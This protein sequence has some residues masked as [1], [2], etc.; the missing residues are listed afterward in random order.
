MY[1]NIIEDKLMTVLI[2]RSS[3]N[4]N[5]DLMF[6]WNNGMKL[7]VRIVTFFE[8][9]NC[10]EMD[11]PQYEEYYACE[12][13]VENVISH[14]EKEMD[15]IPNTSI[16]YGNSIEISYRNTPEFIYSENV[17]IFNRSRLISPVQSGV[18]FRELMNQYSF[19]DGVV[20]KYYYDSVKSRML[21]EIELCSIPGDDDLDPSYEPLKMWLVFNSITRFVHEPS[22]LDFC[23][24]EILTT[25]VLSE[26]EV[27]GERV[28]IVLRG[29]DVKVLEF[30][31]K[32]V[33]MELF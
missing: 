13:K 7:I 12:V 20:L 25:S 11:D 17:M 1:K 30:N 22:V 33:G 5:T 15:S 26:N 18:K 2:E 29:N 16:L 32:S 6:V 4:P 9:D 19:H 8:T 23:D 24:D 27:T 21:F 3:K 14:S 28:K 10:L 31:V